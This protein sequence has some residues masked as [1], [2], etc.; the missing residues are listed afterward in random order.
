L[1]LEHVLI[2]NLFF[3]LSEVPVYKIGLL[4]DVLHATAPPG[5]TFRVLPHDDER[6]ENRFVPDVYMTE[7]KRELENLLASK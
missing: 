5:V 1:R 6:E 2:P 3:Q 7:T 4:I